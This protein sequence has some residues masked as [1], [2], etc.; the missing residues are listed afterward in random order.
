LF[1]WD[2]SI[3]CILIFLFGQSNSIFHTSQF[4]AKMGQW[5][6][7]RYCHTVHDCNR[8]RRKNSERCNGIVWKEEKITESERGNGNERSGINPCSSWEWCR[9]VCKRRRLKEMTVT[10]AQTTV[11]EAVSRWLLQPWLPT[12]NCNSNSASTF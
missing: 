6:P 11:I 2:N 4:T 5:R 3:S 8:K 7:M 9:R 10:E 1:G 12:I